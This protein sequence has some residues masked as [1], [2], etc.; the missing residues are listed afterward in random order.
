ML[1]TPWLS[2]ALPGELSRCSRI[3]DNAIPRQTYDQ[4]VAFAQQNQAIVQARRAGLEKTRL[5][6]SYAEVRSPAPGKASWAI[7]S[8][9]DPVVAI[10]KSVT[11]DESFADEDT[12]LG[13]SKL[14]GKRCLRY[15]CTIAIR[16]APTVFPQL[17]LQS[18]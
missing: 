16:D 2:S 6:R 10:S 4:A 8:T 18:L 3:P 7:V 1:D 13:S 12:I 9:L 5:D 14:S 11:K 17:D 15:V